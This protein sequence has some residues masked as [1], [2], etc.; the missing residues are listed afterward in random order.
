[1]LLDFSMP[2]MGGLEALPQILSSSPS[3][4]VAIL[5]PVTAVTGATRSL[6]VPRRA[7]ARQSSPRGSSPPCS[8]SP[9]ADLLG[10]RSL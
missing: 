8:S 5:S 9:V 2:K 1:V 7:S 10:W 6:R 3:T 4:K